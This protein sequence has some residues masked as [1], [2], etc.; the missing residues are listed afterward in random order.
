MPRQL[1]WK[2]SQRFH[3]LSMGVSACLIAE[4]IVLSICMGA[5]CFLG[6]IS[7]PLNIYG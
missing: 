2:W 1:M 3:H 7:L 5:A 6:S 4:Y